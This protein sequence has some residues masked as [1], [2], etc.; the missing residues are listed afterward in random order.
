[1]K[2][3][4]KLLFSRSTRYVTFRACVRVVIQHVQIVHEEKY[5][6]RQKKKGLSLV[7]RAPS[8]CQFTRIDLLEPSCILDSKEISW[9]QL[10][11]RQGPGLS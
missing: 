7:S 6:V 3:N 1:M 4:Q 9:S 10:F 11:Y 5:F 2:I 8:F